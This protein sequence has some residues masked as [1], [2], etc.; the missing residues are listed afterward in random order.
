MPLDVQR[1]YQA[2]A[3]RRRLVQIT[4]QDGGFLGMCTFFLLRSEQDIQRFYERP[5]WTAPLDEAT[6]TWV[7][8]DQ[9]W[10]Q[11]WDKELRRGLEDAIIAQHPQV[12]RATWYRPSRGADRRYTCYVGQGEGHG[13]D[14]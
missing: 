7:Y 4:D 11:T 14:L 2:M 9:L 5:V 1:Y 8:V 13:T 12:T 3:E 6:G 10:C